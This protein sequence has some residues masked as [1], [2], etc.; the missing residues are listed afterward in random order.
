MHYIKKSKA[1]GELVE[2]KKAQKGKNTKG[3]V[4][5]RKAPQGKGSGLEGDNLEE[6]QSE[7]G[8]GTQ[9]GPAK[10]TYLLQKARG[11]VWTPTVFSC[12]TIQVKQGGG[13]KKTRS[14]LNESAHPKEKTR[15]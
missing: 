1:F 2:N 10:K 8:G 5:G 7:I 9:K 3:G 15:F 13:R 14:G 12:S 11:G 6:L 4:R